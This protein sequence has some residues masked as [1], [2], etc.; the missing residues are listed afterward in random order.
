MRDR[1]GT[2]SEVVRG[3]G[4]VM[5]RGGGAGG[6]GVGGG[7]WGVG[8]PRARA[9]AGEPWPAALSIYSVLPGYFG[10]RC[11]STCSLS[12]KAYADGWAYGSPGVGQPLNAPVSYWYQSTASTTGMIGTS[13]SMACWI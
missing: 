7:G 13:F 2:G 1:G 10:D 4:A 3:G 6:V 8:D 5:G 9:L 11:S 12:G